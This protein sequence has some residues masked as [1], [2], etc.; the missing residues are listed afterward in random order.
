MCV[1]RVLVAVLAVS[2]LAAA[3]DVAEPVNVERW[4]SRLWEPVGS[5]GGL[6]SPDDLEDVAVILHR[7]DAIPGDSTLPIGSR[8]LAI[9]ELRPNGTYV[10][11][12]LAERILPCVQ[13]LGTLSREARGVP[14]EIDIEDRRLVVGWIGNADGFL[15]VR[16]T[17]AWDERYQAY[18]LV[19]DDVARGDPATGLKTRRIRDFVAGKERR[20]GEEVAIEPRFIPIESVS[21][22]DYR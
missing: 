14:F 19:A 3:V 13:C 5:A 16:L 2:G 8:G 15:A 10:R 21:A 20:D 17:I 11:Q 18:A 9:F 7:R 4:V 1:F 12:A 6:L 22:D